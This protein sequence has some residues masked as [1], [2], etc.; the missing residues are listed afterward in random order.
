MSAPATTRRWLAGLGAAV[1]VVGGAWMVRQ[2][3]RGGAVAE[4]TDALTTPPAEAAVATAKVPPVHID[5]GQEVYAIDLGAVVEIDFEAAG[6][7][8]V[9]RRSRDSA[10][11]RVDGED[12]SVSVEADGAPKPPSCR[13]NPALADLLGRLSSIRVTRV[14]GDDETAVLR[15][16][17]GANAAT[18][19][20]RDRTVLDPKEFRVLFP[21]ELP[22][23]ALLLD[24]P[25]VFES[26][27]PRELFDRLSAGCDVLGL[28]G[29][30]RPR[31]N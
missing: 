21:D 15:Q 2:S 27:L 23:R 13:G 30:P 17:Y 22:A 10:P 6:R 24:G 29:Q 14:L 28:S 20:I 5:P 31:K 7:K 8:V 3:L 12:F 11:G 19:R 9:I 25:A 26:S 4:R 16:R 18:L 1:V